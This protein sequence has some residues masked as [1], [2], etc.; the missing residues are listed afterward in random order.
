MLLHGHTVMAL[1]FAVAFA[2]VHLRYSVNPGAN[3]E[4]G[5]GCA[6]TEFSQGLTRTAASAEHLQLHRGIPRGSTQVG[7]Y[8]GRTIGVGPVAVDY[9]EE[10]VDNVQPEGRSRQRISAGGVSSG[11]DNR[12]VQHPLR[13]NGLSELGIDCRSVSDRHY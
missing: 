12:Y 1:H 11:T 4:P 7:G 13:T 6:R 2:A 10:E 5:H 9:R 3:R 8:E